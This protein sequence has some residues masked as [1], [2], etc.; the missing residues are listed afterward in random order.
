ML[1]EATGNAA[2]SAWSK[3]GQRLPETG[4]RARADLNGSVESD[5][6]PLGFSNLSRLGIKGQTSHGA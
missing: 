4:K 6:Q 1:G 5:N 3:S 2:A